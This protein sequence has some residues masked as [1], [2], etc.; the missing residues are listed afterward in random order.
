MKLTAISI[1]PEYFAPLELSLIGK[2]RSQGLVNFSSINLRDFTYDNHHT[3]DDTPYGGG[4][5]MVMKPEPWGEAI[6]SQIQGQNVVDLVIL[7]PAGTKFSQRFAQTFST[8]EHIIFA[9]GR[10]EGID[11]RVAEHYRSIPSVRVHEISIGDFVLNGGEVAALVMIE[12]IVRLIPGVI[13]NPESLLEESHNEMGE[14]EY[15]TF[16]KPATWRGLSVPDVLL[17]GNHGEIARWR[18]EEAQRRSQSR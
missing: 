12:A 7:T 14:V 16:T 8:S 9:C 2:A 6:D 13:G 15:P 11:A 4:A 17:S 10:Y 3:V 5:G 18:S 1:F